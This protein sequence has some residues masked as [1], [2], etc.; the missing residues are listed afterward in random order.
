M[1]EGDDSNHRLEI[2]HRDTKITSG[3][4]IMI[5]KIISILAELKEDEGLIEKLNGDSSIVDDVGLDSLQM[6]N[7]MLRIEEEF[8][9]EIDFDNFDFSYLSS[10][11]SF[12]AYI[13]GCNN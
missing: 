5:E 13:S 2:T 12:V 11:Q 9:I 7:F 3:G 8:E 1:G 10:I 6:I 4:E